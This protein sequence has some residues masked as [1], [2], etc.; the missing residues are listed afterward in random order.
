MVY[1]YKAFVDIDDGVDTGPE[2]TYH[3]VQSSQ[4][5]H[6]GISLKIQM[7]TNQH[8]HPQVIKYN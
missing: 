2:K 5:E 7:S 3:L 1:L 4:S 6:G 8:A